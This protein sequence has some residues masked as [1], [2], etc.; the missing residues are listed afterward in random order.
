MANDVQQAFVGESKVLVGEAGG[1]TRALDQEAPS[2]FEL[3][4]FG[5]AREAQ[6]FHAILQGLRNGV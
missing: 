2:N 6:D 4:L 1:F 3:F 5:V